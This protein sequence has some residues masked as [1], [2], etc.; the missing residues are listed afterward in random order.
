MLFINSHP[1]HILAL[2]GQKEYYGITLLP[3]KEYKFMSKI[4]L[5]PSFIMATLLECKRNHEPYN[6][7]HETKVQVS[8]DNI[9]II[10]GRIDSR[11]FADREGEL[12]DITGKF[13]EILQYAL[14][15][16]SKTVLTLEIDQ[17]RLLLKAT[18]HQDIEESSRMVLL[19]MIEKVNNISISIYAEE[20]EKIVSNIEE[21]GKRYMILKEMGV[22]DIGLTREQ[23]IKIIESFDRQY[24]INNHEKKYLLSYLYGVP[25]A[26]EEKTIPSILQ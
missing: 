16:S 18:L 8:I 2:E 14:F 9:D 12:T 11:I 20:K 1:S 19:N 3:N 4:L 6:I 22:F 13:I 24:K 10:I 25:S 17:E 15:I 23:K 21:D 7:L 26:E 5:P